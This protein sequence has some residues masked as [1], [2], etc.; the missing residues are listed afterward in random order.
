MTILRKK[1]SFRLG[2]VFGCSLKDT[3][4]KF[5]VWK[6]LKLSVRL[7]FEVPVQLISSWICLRSRTSIYLHILSQKKVLLDLYLPWITVHEENEDEGLRHSEI[8]T[9]RRTLTRSMMH[10][11]RSKVTIYIIKATSKGVLILVKR[12]DK[13]SESL[14]EALKKSRLTRWWR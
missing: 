6:S 9:A 5:F 10:W 11:N 8:W 4:E 3:L 12:L 1:H 13:D 2:S 14:K 7:C